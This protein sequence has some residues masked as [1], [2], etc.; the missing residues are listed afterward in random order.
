MKTLFPAIRV[1]DIDASLSFY[2]SVGYEVVGTVA[3]TVGDRL[4][5]QAL[6]GEAE[7][8]LELV[9]RPGDGPAG[10]RGGTVR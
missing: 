6:P 1:S 9:H 4:A 5:M 10:S 3:V 7:I 2:R 8:S